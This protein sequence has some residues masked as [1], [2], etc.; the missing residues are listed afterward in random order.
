MMYVLGEIGNSSENYTTGNWRILYS[1]KHPGHKR[2]TRSNVFNLGNR[3]EKKVRF[4]NHNYT[5]TIQ[6]GD[7]AHLRCF[8]RNYTE[9]AVYWLKVDQKTKE[10]K[11][12]TSNFT[13]THMDKRFKQ[14]K[15]ERSENW[16]LSIKYTQKSDEGYYSCR[17]TTLEEPPIYIY[18]ELKLVEAVA[19]ILETDDEIPGKIK[20]KLFSP[21]RLSCVL[22]NSITP[23]QYIF[24]YHF[25]TMINYDLEDNASVRRGTQGS[26]LIFPKTEQSHQGNYSCVPS[27]AKQASIVVEV[28]GE[29]DLLMGNTAKRKMGNLDFFPYLLISHYIKNLIFFVGEV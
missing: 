5:E 21:L 8:I 22:N 27:N 18:I 1:Y 29:S 24:W 16:E 7:E 19:Q 14:N 4:L 10:E 26:E 25:D 17:V 20:V 9:M 15:R 13:T 3:G 12:L 6:I 11:E 23:P 2:G 28:Y